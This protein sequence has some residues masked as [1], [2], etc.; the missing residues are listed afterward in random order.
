MVMPFSFFS[1]PIASMLWFA[2]GGLLFCYAVYSTLTLAGWTPPAV[3]LGCLL[4]LTSPL[5]LML[6]QS[7]TIA[8][9]TLTIATALL[10]QE[11]RLWLA[12]AFLTIS[13]ALKP[14][15]VGLILVYFLLQ[16]RY[17]VRALQTV[18]I[19]AVLAVVSSLW[20]TVHPSSSNWF[21]ELRTTMARSTGPGGNGDPS[22][23]NQDGA[24][25]V[26]LQV[27]TTLTTE[28]RKMADMMAWGAVAILLAG[29]LFGVSQARPTLE[30]DLLA[31]ACICC[32]SLLPIYHRMYD[33]RLLL[34]AIPASVLMLKDAPLAGGL[35]TC[36]TGLIFLSTHRLYIES[37]HKIAM[38]IGP[39][40][41]P[42]AA[43][44]GNSGCD[45]VLP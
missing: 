41:R 11:K 16:K 28:N 44:G 8:I 26:N 40:S 4:L 38:K 13:V 33:T 15:L 35:A 5:L 45:P 18:A 24:S 12:V 25:M 42:T 29:W 27:D 2:V 23:A 10:L 6:G 17:R 9:A 14:H 1:F 34:L 3:A 36:L 43:L 32:I 19:V 31:V 7:A 22:L 21:M 39:L 20:L 30:N 37:S